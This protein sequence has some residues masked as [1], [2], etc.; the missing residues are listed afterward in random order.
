MTDLKEFYIAKCWYTNENLL[1]KIPKALEE[2]KDFPIKKE[3]TL[4]IIPVKD[5]LLIKNV[6]I[7]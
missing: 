3:I 4:L 1:I 2:H 6:T 5:G 7:K